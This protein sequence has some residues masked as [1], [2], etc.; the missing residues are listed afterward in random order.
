MNPTGAADADHEAKPQP[1]GW[2]DARH[3]LATRHR[4]GAG[5]GR[6]AGHWWTVPARTMVRVAG[7]AHVAA[8]GR[9]VRAGVERSLRDDRN[10]P[11][12]GA[13]F[14]ARSRSPPR[15]VGDGPAAGVERRMDTT[16]LRPAV[17]AA[18]LCRH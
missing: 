8:A 18:G 3:E 17:T 4:G 6:G 12:P 13:G 11:G 16:F 9:G 15:A 7:Q 5:G 10:Q 2:K 14:A 1:N